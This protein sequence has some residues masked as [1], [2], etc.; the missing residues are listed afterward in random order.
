MKT[1]QTVFC[2]LLIGLVPEVSG[3]YL[4]VSDNDRFLVSDKGEPFFWMGDTGWELF[5]KLTLPEAEYYLRNR[6]AKGF[7]VIQ[8]VILSECDGLTTPTP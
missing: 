6:S 3:Q 7:T 5:H 4:R 8:A 1:I 2:L